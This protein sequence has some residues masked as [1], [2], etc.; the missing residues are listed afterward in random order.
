MFSMFKKE[1]VLNEKLGRKYRDSI[2]APGGSRD[3]MD[4]L[5]EFLGRKPTSDAFLEEIGVKK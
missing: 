5:I 4:S 1:G 2:L 3:S